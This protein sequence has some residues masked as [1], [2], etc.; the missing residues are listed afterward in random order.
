MM[1]YPTIHRYSRALLVSMLGMAGTAAAHPGAHAGSAEHS[2][3]LSGLKHFFTSIDHV[4]PVIAAILLAVYAFRRRAALG[5]TFSKW[6]GKGK[7][8]DIDDQ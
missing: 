5:A 3:T 1:K 2:T 4:G 6:R 8:P 7:S